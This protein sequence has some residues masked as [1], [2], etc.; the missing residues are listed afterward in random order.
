MLTWGHSAYRFL[1]GL[2]ISLVPPK[3]ICLKSMSECAA[4]YSAQLTDESSVPVLALFALLFSRA[5][6]T[7]LVKRAGAQKKSVPLAAAGASL[8]VHP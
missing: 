4:N 8:L 3:P 6:T 2:V 7:P 1:A 5:L